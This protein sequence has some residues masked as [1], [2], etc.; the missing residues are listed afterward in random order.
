MLS[1]EITLNASVTLSEAKGPEPVSLNAFSKI[2]PT[3]V[4]L[5]DQLEL[6]SAVPRF[7]LFL[8]SNRRQDVLG[9]FTVDQSEYLMLGSLTG[10][11]EFPSVLRYP[12]VHVIRHSYVELARF[13]CQ[14]VHIVAP[15]HPRESHRMN[16][17]A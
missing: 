10:R 2:L 3:W 6:S 8:S 5:L 17:S 15:I 9:C 12:L 1:S 14:N 13:T 16:N 11:M 7:D 4:S